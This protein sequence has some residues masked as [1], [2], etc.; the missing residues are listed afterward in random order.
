MEFSS[1]RGYLSW[2]G[3]DLHQLTDYA[4]Q[5]KNIANSQVFIKKK[6][7]CALR[8]NPYREAVWG[9]HINHSLVWF[10]WKWRKCWLEMAGLWLCYSHAGS[11]H[12]KL[13]FWN[14][15]I[16]AKNYSVLKSFGS[17]HWSEVLWIH[18]CVCILGCFFKKKISFLLLFGCCFSGFVF[19]WF[20]FPYKY[21]L[22]RVC[23]LLT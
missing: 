20:F 9:L 18:F 8:N 3:Y 2:T 7:V 5:L 11:F 15:Q 23:F 6:R 4:R 13:K 17:E 14:I 12:S 19:C 22:W 10:V 16:S 1:L 21:V